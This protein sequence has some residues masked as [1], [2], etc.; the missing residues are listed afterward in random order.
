MFSRIK[1]KYS[2]TSGNSV[3]MVNKDVTNKLKI[4]KANFGINWK[5]I[6]DKKEST[7]CDHFKRENASPI[8][9]IV[10]IKI[11]GISISII[12]VKAHH[13]NK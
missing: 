9:V 5:L 7:G 8:V 4:F 3:F 12:E 11:I 1:K 6:K 13:E 10:A 2:T